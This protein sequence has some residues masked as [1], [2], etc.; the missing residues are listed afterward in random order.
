VSEENVEIVLGAFRAF[1]DRDDEAA[2]A[3]YKPD[4]EWDLSEH[5]GWMEQPY[6]RGHDGIREFFRL[7]LAAFDVYWAEARD[8]LDVGERVVVT[9]FE[10]GRGKRSDV[11]VDRE[12]GQVWTLHDGLVAR[13]Q[14]FDSRHNALQA[15]GLE[16]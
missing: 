2:F 13:V 4:V 8:P 3:I 10:H 7:W 12:H 1:A 11:P 15:I 9:I 16:E 5:S 6:F 14:Q